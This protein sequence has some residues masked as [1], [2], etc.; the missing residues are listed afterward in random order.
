[1]P[2]CYYICSDSWGN[3]R[4]GF[5]ICLGRRL[6]YCL[7]PDRWYAVP[8]CCCYYD[9]GRVTVSCTNPTGRTFTRSCRCCR[10][11]NHMMG[12]HTPTAT[13][14]DDVATVHVAPPDHVAPLVDVAVV[15]VA[16][17]HDAPANTAVDE[18]PPNT[19]TIYVG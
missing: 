5:S 6:L 10:D 16:V 18:A 3:F 9:D 1:M 15:H 19:P 8:H 2:S 12:I 14:P 11:V 4:R 17:V 13:R 7:R